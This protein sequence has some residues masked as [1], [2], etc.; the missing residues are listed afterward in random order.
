M[1]LLAVGATFLGGLFLLLLLL[2]RFGPGS[3]AEVLDWDPSDRIDQ[4]AVEEHRDTQRL[5]DAINERRAAHGQ[6]PLQ[7]AD[8]VR[9]LRR[10][11]DDG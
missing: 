6:P 1:S 4:L 7:E 9:Q 10:H 3:G 5:L 11:D 8:V 2:G